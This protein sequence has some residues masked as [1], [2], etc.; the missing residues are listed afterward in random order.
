MKLLQGLPKRITVVAIGLLVLEILLVLRV[1]VPWLVGR[2]NA[3][4]FYYYLVLA[5]NNAAGYGPSFDGVELTNG[6]HPLYL[7]FV[8]LLAMLPVTDPAFLIKSSL[9][10][11]LIFHNLTGVVI[12]GGFK[13]RGRTD[14]GEIMALAWLLNP[15]SLA[16]TLHGVEAPIATF[17]WVMVIFGL[18]F[19]RQKEQKSIGQATGLGV[20]IGFAILARTDSL[21]LLGAI[22]LAEL[23]RA[24]YNPAG[25]RQIVLGAVA[26]GGGAFLVTLPWWWWNWQTFD[27]ILQVSSKAIFLGTHGFDWLKPELILAQTGSAGQGYLSRVILYS[28]LPLLLLGLGFWQYQK[29]RYQGRFSAFQFLS[30]LDFALLAIIGL[31]LWYPG[32][33]WN[34]QNWYLLST[35]GLS[36]AGTRLLFSPMAQPA[37]GTRG[38]YWGLEQRHYWLFCRKKCG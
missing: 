23:Y 36:P 10:L 6:F 17:L 7:V 38:R 16:I 1:S 15:W 22:L 27:M 11:L 31:G 32:W 2:V 19:Y 8:T 28:A 14:I 20:V 29:G 34:V 13:L 26:M 9:I 5:R 24:W 30:E 33:Q 18:I 21:L 3:D 4:D 37:Y 35:I 12:G 25:Q